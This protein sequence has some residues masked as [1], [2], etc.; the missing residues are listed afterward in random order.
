MKGVT[1]IYNRPPRLYWLVRLFFPEYRFEKTLAFSF[2]DTIYSQESP[3]PEDIFVHEEVH[4]EQMKWS[5]LYG[6]IHF[7]RCFF[8]KKYYYEAEVEGYI[9]QFHW[10]IKKYGKN[11]ILPTLNLVVKHLSKQDIYKHGKSYEEVFDDLSK[12]IDLTA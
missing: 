1:N 8:S 11:S 9:A 6:I 10:L 3:L 12:R 2:G 4:L 5:K 7:L